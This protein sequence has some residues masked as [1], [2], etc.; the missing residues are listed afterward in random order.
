MMN[1]YK[2]RIGRVVIGDRGA[3]QSVPRPQLSSEQLADLNARFSRVLKQY[4]VRRNCQPATA[5]DLA[6]D[7]FVRLASRAA[8]TEIENIEAYLMQTA[9]SVWKDH[10]RRRQSR[11]HSAHIEF[12]D[13]QHGFEELSPDRVYEGRETIARVLEALNAL[14]ERPRQVFF[15]RRFEGMSQKEVAKRLGVSVSLVE[16]EMMK[17]IAHVADWFGEEV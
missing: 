9:S 2:K 12:D 17:A 13:P 3:L 4:F 15:L 5:E 14:D 7:V 16:K 8:T 10:C 6:Q 1:E 11:A